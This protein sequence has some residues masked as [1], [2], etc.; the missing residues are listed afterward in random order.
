LIPIIL[1][2]QRPELTLQLFTKLHQINS[3]FQKK[4]G[5]YVFSWIVLAHDGLQ[6]KAGSEIRRYHEQTRQLCRDLEKDKANVKTLLFDKNI[7]LTQH[8]FRC[9]D[10]QGIN[11]RD[12]ILFEE[13][14]IPTLEA[15]EFLKSSKDLMNPSCILD[16]LPINQHLGLELN[17]VST[18]FTDNGN[19]V[20]GEEL[21]NLAKELWIKKDL[22]QNEFE[23]NLLFYFSNFLSGFSLRR[24]YGYYSKFFS[25]GLTNI[26][27]PDSLLSY[28]LIL[29][30]KLKVC[31]T[32]PLSENWSD[33]DTRGK[34]VNI[35]P[36]N[37]GIDCNF[38]TTE[39]WG[40]NTC[41][42]CEK[43]GVS[44]RIEL[45]RIG[46]L[47]VGLN[48]RISKHRNSKQKQ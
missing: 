15:I 39:I 38:S 6:D 5:E 2:Y 8:I 29:S 3:D 42:R 10:A 26:D 37:R 28:A 4:N 24:A 48:Y 35:V 11:S 30:Q 13:D 23:K 34:N 14:K 41:T 45:N 40:F 17:Y 22:F 43:Q 7:G 21:L 18:L 27:R 16:T 19:V 31:P 46:A 12:C 9:I 20:I 47:K 44:E 32:F 36:N 25:W 1:A 33:R